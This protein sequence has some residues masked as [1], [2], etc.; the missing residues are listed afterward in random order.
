MRQG[1]RKA[2]LSLSDP[3]QFSSLPQKNKPSSSLTMTML[4]H[5]K[6][7]HTVQSEY[8][9][10]CAGW[11]PLGTGGHSNSG[12]SAPAH[13]SRRAQS[14]LSGGPLKVFPV[15]V[16]FNRLVAVRS[17]SARVTKGSRST[18]IKG[19]EIIYIQMK[20]G[21]TQRGRGSHI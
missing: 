6:R 8:P 14:A 10:R 1:S 5:T 15:F 7:I 13:P 18:G 19:V 16:L 11:A 4:K 12:A 17:V 2:K 9:Q 3:V 20:E 21:E